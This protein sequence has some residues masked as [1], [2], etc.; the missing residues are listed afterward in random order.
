MLLTIAPG[1]TLANQ[2]PFE[3]KGRK[4]Q[5]KFEKPGKRKKI[6]ITTPDKWFSKYIRIRDIVS[7]E[8]CMCVTCGKAIHWR[9]EAQCGHFATRGHPMT[10]FNK[11]NCNAQCVACNNYQ[12]GHQ[13]KHGFAIDR[14]YGPGT[15]QE[16]IDQSEIRGQREFSKLA[17]K[18]LAREFRLAAQ[19]LAKQKGIIL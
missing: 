13:A 3:T 18:D 17:L 5:L 4:M 6:R 16:L 8:H 11:R 15:A 14:M 12:K 7:G 19:L 2:K 1:A 9:Y 10:R